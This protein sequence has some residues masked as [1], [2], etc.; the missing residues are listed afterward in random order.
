VAGT[1]G[2]FGTLVSVGGMGRL[3]PQADSKKHVINRE[4]RKG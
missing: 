1:L 3:L 2:V 4:E